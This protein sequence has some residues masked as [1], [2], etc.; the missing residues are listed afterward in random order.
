MT[1]DRGPIFD[2]V[3]IGHPATGALIDAGY[4]TVADLPDELTEPRCTAS[5]HRRSVV[6]M[7]SATRSERRRSPLAAGRSESRRRTV[8]FMGIR[9]RARMYAGAALLIC[10]LALTGCGD[11]SD[12]DSNSG[13]EESSNTHDDA[14]PTDDPSDDGPGADE[15]APAIND[16]TVTV[17]LDGKALPIDSVDCVTGAAGDGIYFNNVT[18]DRIQTLDLTVSENDE[19]A[20]LVVYVGT[21]YVITYSADAPE[22]AKSNLD[23]AVDGDT[24][25]VTGTTP[26]TPGGEP[27]KVEITATCG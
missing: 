10:G 11:D 3:K 19:L 26:G 15:A 25:T 9:T 7:L 23:L 13:G 16:A 1:A 24:Y 22:A 8:P 4:A 2:G 14:T 5:V 27:A 18:S 6:W 20:G 21:E 17:S 12:D